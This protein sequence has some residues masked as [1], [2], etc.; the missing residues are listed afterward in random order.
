MSHLWG[1]TATFQPPKETTSS[2]LQSASFRHKIDL[3]TVEDPIFTNSDLVPVLGPAH[4]KPTRTQVH[5]GL[6]LTPSRCQS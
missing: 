4:A 2:N 3:R 1:V 6:H 5:W